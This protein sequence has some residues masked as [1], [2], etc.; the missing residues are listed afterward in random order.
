MPSTNTCISPP[1]RAGQDVAVYYIEANKPSVYR[2]RSEFRRC[3]LLHTVPTPMRLTPDIRHG[4]N[5]LHHTRPRRLGSSKIERGEQSV[6]P[7]TAESCPPYSLG[8][9]F[10]RTTESWRFITVTIHI[11]DSTPLRFFVK[12]II[13]LPA[14]LPRGDNP[15]L[16]SPP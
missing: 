11:A 4:A 6:L 15:L 9:F 14:T 13:T 1:I 10:E 5:F 12:E 3:A 7:P 16:L 2:Q 8:I